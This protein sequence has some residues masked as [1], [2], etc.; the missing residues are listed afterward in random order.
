MRVD[1]VHAHFGKLSTVT[2]DVRTLFHKSTAIIIYQHTSTRP[3]FCGSTP[4][5]IPRTCAFELDSFPS[6]CACSCSLLVV[7][8]FCSGSLICFAVFHP[9]LVYSPVRI[10]NVQPCIIRFSHAPFAISLCMCVLARPTQNLFI[11]FDF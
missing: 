2:N 7:I 5:T 3:I 10:D 8:P 4:S 9:L 1:C 11:L 6:S